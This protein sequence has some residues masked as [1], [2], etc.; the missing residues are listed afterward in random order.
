MAMPPMSFSG[1]GGSAGPSSAGNSG[2]TQG[3]GL[4]VGDFYA[5]GSRV[6]KDNGI[7]WKMMAIIGVVGL[8]GLK[9]WQK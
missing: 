6:R 8:V 7:D 2:D 1:S 5:S 4:S 3:L 9:V